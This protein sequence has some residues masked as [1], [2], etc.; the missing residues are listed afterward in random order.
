MAVAE[1]VAHGLP[2]VS[3]TTG[4]IPDLVAW[5]EEDAAG[6][7]VAPGDIRAFGDA[8]SSVLGDPI[9]DSPRGGAAL[10][11]RLATNARR[12]RERLPTWEQAVEK[13]ATALE[14]IDEPS[15]AAQ[16]GN[17]RRMAADE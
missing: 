14:S 15:R 8:L 12:V 10:R 13:M 1:A 5:G 16:A 3:T 6:L 7:L 17:S 4:A 11:R 9:G 2:V